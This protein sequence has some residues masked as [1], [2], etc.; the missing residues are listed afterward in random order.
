MKKNP[1]KTGS[2]KN[3]TVCLPELRNYLRSSKVEMP[4]MYGRILPCIIMHPSV[5]P[6]R[7]RSITI[8][9]ADGDGH[10]C[11]PSQHFPLYRERRRDHWARWPWQ[12]WHN[13]LLRCTQGDT[14][15]PGCKRCQCGIIPCLQ[16]PHHS[17]CAIGAWNT[18]TWSPEHQQHA[19]C[20]QWVTLRFMEINSYVWFSEIT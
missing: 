15:K 18:G 11:R 8:T 3:K 13:T 17:H 20:E 7:V 9:R 14:P 2:K 12:S 1:N 5:Q 19:T 4:E 10:S 16:I 6:E